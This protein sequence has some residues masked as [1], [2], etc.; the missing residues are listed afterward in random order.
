MLIFSCK[1]NKSNSIQNCLKRLHNHS[2]MPI[3][4]NPLIW[5]LHKWKYLIL[6]DY[7]LC[8]ELDGCN[9]ED[10]SCK[11]N[12]F[13][14]CVKTVAWVKNKRLS[15]VIYY[16]FDWMSHV[17]G[18]YMHTCCFTSVTFFINAPIC[19]ACTLFCECE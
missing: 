17:Q 8:I 10:N 7:L 16:K 14:S 13:S 11:M 18:R 2:V 19:A 3:L 4:Y 15:T 9:P 1:F 6:F 12:N 5:I